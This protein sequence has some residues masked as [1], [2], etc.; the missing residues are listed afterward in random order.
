MLWVDNLTYK[1]CYSS[2]GC[3][4]RFKPIFVL[5]CVF[6]LYG[7]EANENMFPILLLNHRSQLLPKVNPTYKPL[8][9]HLHIIEDWL[10]SYILCMYHRHIHW[11][12]CHAS[13]MFTN[14]QSLL[15]ITII[16]VHC[17]YGLSYQITNKCMCVCMSIHALGDDI[18]SNL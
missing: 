2:Q 9:P 14:N 18:A 11:I 1:P 4:Q 13:D 3:Q 15:S 17:E 7:D 6:I 5:S 8:L 10:S 12:M 16:S